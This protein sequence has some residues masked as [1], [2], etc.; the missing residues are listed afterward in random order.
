[1]NSAAKDLLE[2]VSRPGGVVYPP[3]I[4]DEGDV[5][6]PCRNGDVILVPDDPRYAGKGT[7]YI[8]DSD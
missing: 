2:L 6:I 7:Y 8:I 3:Y 5:V 1:M 4:T